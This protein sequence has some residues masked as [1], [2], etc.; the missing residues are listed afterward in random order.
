LIRRTAAALLLVATALPL[1]AAAQSPVPGATPCPATLKFAGALYL[2]A[3]RTVPASEVGSRVGET[4]PNPA[5]CGIPDRV[6]VY[7]HQ[8]HAT[9]DEVV[10]LSADG[11]A[12][13]FTSAGQTGLPLVSIL[14][15]VVLA[16]VVVVLLYAALPALYTHMIQP[17]V[18]VGDNAPPPG[19][20]LPSTP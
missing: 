11:S 10:H 2:D 12:E 18:E 13:L 4:D 5:A 1:Q 3:D 19:D 8:G 17:P 6:T 15:W 14:R 9:T 20:E 16:L 7:G